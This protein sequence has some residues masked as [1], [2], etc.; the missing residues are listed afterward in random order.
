MPEY[1]PITVVSEISEIVSEA[2]KRHFDKLSESIETVCREIGITKDTADKFRI[3]VEE[4]KDLT[5]K[6]YFFQKVDEKIS[7]K[8]KTKCFVTIRTLVA[9]FE[10]R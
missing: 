4:S 7:A 6:T 2:S 9:K 5:V 10:I 8:R 3:L 1:V